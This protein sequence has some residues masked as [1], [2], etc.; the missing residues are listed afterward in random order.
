MGVA[1]LYVG[2]DAACE[3]TRFWVSSPPVPPKT[4]DKC[5]RYTGC[6]ISSLSADTYLLT[7]PL[8]FENFLVVSFKLTF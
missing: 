1:L 7:F 5:H 2:S 6:S 4:R 3:H 8:V